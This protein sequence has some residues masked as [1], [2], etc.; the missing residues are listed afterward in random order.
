MLTI[1]QFP[2]IVIRLWVCVLVFPAGEITRGGY[3]SFRKWDL[4]NN[5]GLLRGESL[6]VLAKA[7]VQASFFTTCPCVMK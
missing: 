6:K 2:E 5:R 3:R 1:V 7:L 4:A